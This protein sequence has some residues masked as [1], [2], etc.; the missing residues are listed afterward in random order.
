MVF[1]AFKKE[2]QPPSAID[3][4]IRMTHGNSPPPKSANLIVAIKIAHTKLLFG[5]VD[6]KEV[7]QIATSL[8]N[9]PMPYSTHDLAVATTMNLFRSADSE[10]QKDLQEVQIDAKLEVLGWVK[11]RK[12]APIIAKSFEDTLYN[13][14]KEPT[15]PPASSTQVAKPGG[16]VLDRGRGNTAKMDGAAGGSIS[17]GREAFLLRP[18]EASLLRR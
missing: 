14:F 2:N 15:A 1:G 4:L 17:T 9:G 16:A 3:A 6:L 11:E 13:M 5:I 18:A 10:R 12:V 7:T 8:F